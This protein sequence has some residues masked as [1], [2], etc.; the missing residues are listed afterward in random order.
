MRLRPNDAIGIVESEKSCLILSLV[1]PDIIWVATN[2]KHKLKPE[3]FEK[4]R[5]RD[6]TVYPDRDGYDD[7]PRK[8]GTGVEKGWRTIARELAT[9]GF[10]LYVDTTVETHYSKYEGTDENGEPKEC[11]KDLADL[12]LEYWRG[13]IK[14]I[15][16]PTSTSTP[17]AIPKVEDPEPMPTPGTPEYSEWASQLAAWICSRREGDTK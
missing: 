8:N 2:G 3:R 1:Y 16:A 9:A 13:V 5:G 4:Y 12:V 10:K 14:P 7:K 11:K 6:V 15:V 17:E